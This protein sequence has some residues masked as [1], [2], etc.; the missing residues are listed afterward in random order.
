VDFGLTGDQEELRGKVRAFAEE[1]L[2]PRYRSEDRRGTI[3]PDLAPT[4]AGAGLMGLRVPRRFGGLEADAV[5]TGLAV[6]EVAR[7]N[8]NSAYVVLNAALVSDILAANASPEQQARWLPEIAAGRT[9]PAVCLTEP[10]H[11]SDA[12]AIETRAEPDGG[13][14]APSGEAA[15]PGWRITG[16]KAS[17]MMGTYARTGVVF[18]RTGGPGARGVSAFYVSFDRPGLSRT[19]STDLG[20]RAM[21]RALLAFDRFP[22]GP[23]DLVGGEG[24]GFVQVMRGFDYSRALLSLM[25]LATAQAAVDD[26][27]ER[28]R[29]RTAFGGPIG[30]HQGVSFPLVEHATFLH[31]ARL[32]CFEALWAKDRGFPHTAEANMAKW[33]APR[34]AVEAAHQAL[35]TFGHAGWSEDLPLAQRLRDLVGL[36]I[37]DGTAGIAKLVV[38][39]AL[40]GRDAAP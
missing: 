17:V 12:A 26:A 15:V 28:A 22:V 36:E 40:L 37:A 10:E 31:A 4:L 7:A 9:I 25:A 16:D 21:G 30:R 23:D 18:A 34:A 3:D 27:L 35:L 2:A 24:L 19:P 33:W 5:S 1:V 29:T 6:E 13:A 20:S 38:A 39:R 32:L 11:G 8:V 14:E